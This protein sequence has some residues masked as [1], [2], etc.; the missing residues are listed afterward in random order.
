M[1]ID[2]LLAH[3]VHL[4]KT[5]K[6]T[7]ARAVYQQV[8]LQSPA[9]VKA[10]NLLGATHVQQGE[11][12]QSLPFIE[13]ALAL[14]P[15]FLEAYNNLGIA[16][17]GLERF[18]QAID[19]YQ[20]ALALR[21]DYAL[22]HYNLGI[23]LSKLH[24]HEEA[25]A[26]YRRALALK[27]DYADAY[28]NLGIALKE[29]KRH[30][31]AIASFHQALAIKPDYADA[32]NN[33]GN[34]LNETQRYEDAAAYY[35]KTLSINPDYAFA[36]GK[37]FHNQAHACDWNDFD[38]ISRK[39][40]DGID[41]GKAVSDPFPLLSIPSSPA[42]QQHCAEIWVR[43]KFPAASTL[44][45]FS[46]KYTHNKIRLAYVSADFCEHPVAHLMAGVFEHHDK[47]RFETIAISLGADDQSPL[48]A[49]IRT[50]FDQFVDVRQMGTTQIAQLMRDMEI[51]I[52]VDLSGYTADSRT[53]I[54]ARRAA[55][56]QVNYLG[57]PGTMGAKF[58]DYI[59]AD[60]HV[61]PEHSRVFYS[62]KV[63]Y[64]PDAYLPTDDNVKISERV[65][66]RTEY[67][68][69][70]TGTV[71][72]SFN[73]NYK[74]SPPM[75]NIWMNLLR[76]L[77]G[78][79]LWLMYR[80]DM[81][82]HKLRHEAAARGVDPYRLVFAARIPLIEDHLA[83]YRLADLFLD[84]HPYNAHTTAADALRAGL[85]VLTCPGDT[86]ASRVAASLLHAIGLPELITHSHAEY[87]ALALELAT[88]PER[89]AAIKQRLAANRATHPLL[90]TAL[91]TRNIEEIFT[92]MQARNQASLLP[93]HIDMR[94]NAGAEA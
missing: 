44:P 42:Q 14:K 25:V 2:A 48:R 28:N 27:P 34:A 69:P 94:A 13:K 26:C 77:P 51:D 61:I 86:F 30:A 21:P 90:D 62:E 4:H 37:Y 49:R 52:A 68:L 20:K 58:M 70:E 57:Y 22:A 15:D 47:S 35:Q 66:T 31:E 38:N 5:G 46:P 39:I 91:F 6:L 23:T 45:V 10:L 64:L 71:F 79:V 50:A 56:I 54:F 18:E 1:N 32:C 87:Q 78:S 9:Q 63:A 33:L 59:L 83:R 29:L 85:P 40:L 80:D 75:F 81:S 82:Q 17:K 73:H 76:H 7:E 8:L 93:D 12:Q 24:R 84:T 65:P 92:R 19:C 41:A 53:E 88:N 72:C 16:L 11:Y 55:P 89:L 60:R 43:E 3:A 67:G 74:I 36:L